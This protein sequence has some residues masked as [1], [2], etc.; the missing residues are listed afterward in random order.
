MLDL[1]EGDKL[2]AA[3]PITPGVTGGGAK[4]TPAG[5][6]KILG[7]AAMPT[8]R[9]DKGVLEPRRAHRERLTTCPPARTTPSA[10]AGSA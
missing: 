1:Y 9:W 5:N 3:V 10:S 8:F 4:E 7:I 2:L 6:W